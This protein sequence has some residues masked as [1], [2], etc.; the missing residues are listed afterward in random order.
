MSLGNILIIEDDMQ[1]QSLLSRTI[2]LEGYK[3]V[4]ASD[5]KSA[6]KILE[7]A[8]VDVT[9]CDV[10]LPDGNGL[11]FAKIFKEKYPFNE[12]ILLTAYGNIQDGIE[13]IRRGAFNYLVKGDDNERLLPLI[14]QAMEKIL[15]QKRVFQLENKMNKQFDFNNIIGDSFAIKQTI[16][17]AKK[18]APTDAAVLLLGETGTGKELFSKAI[19]TNSTRFMFPFVALNCSA[20]PK[21]LLESEL[22][23]HK[24]GSFTGAVNDKKGLMEEADQGTLFLDEIGELDPELQSKLLRVLESKE[25]I[26]VGDTRPTKVDIRLISATNRDLTVE[27]AE[28]RFREDLFYRLNTFSILLPPLRE[29]ASDIPLLAKTFAKVFAKNMNKNISGVSKEFIYLLQQHSW[30]GNVRELRN[31]IERAVLL[32]EKSELTVEDLPHNI[33][34]AFQEGSAQN[35]IS[36]FNLETAEKQHIQRVLSHT[37]GNKVVAA[38]LLNIGL[39]TLYRKI[40]TYQLQF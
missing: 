5:I 36:A 33:Q 7:K 29:H 39:A 34:S 3:V 30:K 9:I 14:S 24:A 13:A 35:P 22:F 26:K 23:G 16:A 37:N 19:H 20:F 21:D 15:L 25:F 10:G 27:V 2:S 12:I 31:V 40:G 1:M 6:Y 17:L 28:G 32:C 4:E 18:V 38:K 11:E 8:P